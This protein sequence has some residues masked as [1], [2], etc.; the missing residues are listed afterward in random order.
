VGRA[1]RTRRWKYS[2]SA[3]EGRGWED[4]W[5]EEFR[6][7]FL[8]DLKHDPH[9]LTNLIRQESHAP[10]AARMRERLI[11]RMTEAGEV[12]PRIVEAERQPSGQRRVSEEEAEE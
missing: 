6:E 8:Y 5:S 3:P 9:E 1:V 7:E 10:V 12:S 11:R 4:S 2:V